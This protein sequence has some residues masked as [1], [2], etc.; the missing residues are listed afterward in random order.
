MRG[1]VGVAGLAVVSLGLAGCG[2]EAPPG[3]Q[4]WADACWEVS[5]ALSAG[6]ADNSE[7]DVTSDSL[8]HAGYSTLANDAEA[9][10]DAISRRNVI[11]AASAIKAFV[12]EIATTNMKDCR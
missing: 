12:A 11:A 3:S 1:L 7:W 10:A 8:N 5:V 9:V 6:T 2:G 4:E